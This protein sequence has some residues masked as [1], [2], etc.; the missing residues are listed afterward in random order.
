MITIQWPTSSPYPSPSPSPCQSIN[1]SI[2]Q[3]QKRWLLIIKAIFFFLLSHDMGSI[4][5]PRC[6]TRIARNERWII[7]QSSS[8]KDRSG[9][10]ILCD[11]YPSVGRNLPDRGLVFEP[12]AIWA[13]PRIGDLCIET[14]A[15]A[16]A[17]WFIMQHKRIELLCPSIQFNSVQFSSV[18][19]SSVKFS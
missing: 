17:S 3:F 12:R 19:F 15:F 13:H 4:V 2:Y 9:N 10:R 7:R 8:A 14:S 16:M 11:S 1:L 5:T 6:H 18:Q